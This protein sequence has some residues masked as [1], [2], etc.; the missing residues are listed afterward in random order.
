IHV[1]GRDENPQFFSISR[2]VSE[3]APGLSVDLLTAASAHDPDS[4]MLSVTNVDASVTTT[5]GRALVEGVDYT[6]TGSDFELTAHG[7]AQFA[8]LPANHSDSFV[9]HYDISD[10]IVA[11]VNTLTV[12]VNGVDEVGPAPPPP[13]ILSEITG[14]YAS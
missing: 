3:D 11:P 2:S 1:T 10:G 9:L 5:G 4:P 8:A 7:L 13:A 6:V 12:T 14:L